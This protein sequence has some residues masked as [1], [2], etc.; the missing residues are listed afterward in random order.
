ML[1]DFRGEKVK[2]YFSVH[3]IS[4]SRKNK[5]VTC[6]EVPRKERNSNIPHA[7]I[8]VSDRGIIGMEVEKVFT[9]VVL[10]L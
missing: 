9:W 4:T 10:A 7:Q 1:P 5:T 8:N 6:L 3:S 2:N